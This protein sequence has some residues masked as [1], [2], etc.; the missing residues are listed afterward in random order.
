[1]KEKKKHLLTPSP[2]ALGFQHVDFGEKQIFR[3]Q[4]RS[5]N[6]NQSYLFFKKI[7]FIYF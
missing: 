3:P 1:M 6:K 2:G 7:L 5:T 4:Q